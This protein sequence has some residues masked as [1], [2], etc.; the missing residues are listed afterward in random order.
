L[1]PLGHGVS[2]NWVNFSQNSTQKGGLIHHSD[3]SG[4][5]LSIRYTER[6][7]EAG[8]EPSFGSVGD[9]YDNA[10]LKLGAVDVRDSQIT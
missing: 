10:L 6:L 3:R 9:S 4:Q 7:A 2:E 5:Y 1:L 8:I